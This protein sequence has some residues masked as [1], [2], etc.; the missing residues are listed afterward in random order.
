MLSADNLEWE[1]LAPTFWLTGKA[2]ECYNKYMKR[3]SKDRQRIYDL[4]IQMFR[5]RGFVNVRIEDI[6]AQAGCSVS[7]FYYQF[8]SKDE[9]LRIYFSSD[10]V[11]TEENMALIL[12]QESPWKQLLLLL[13][14]NME[15]YLNA[16]VD[17][18]RQVYHL[19]LDSGEKLGEKEQNSTSRLTA[20]IVRNAQRA[21]E[22]RNLS[23]PAML[24]A[25]ANELT[26]GILIEWIASN[27]AF[28]M[29]KRMQQGAETLHNVRE[30]LRGLPYPFA[31]LQET[32]KA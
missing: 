24:T 30:D 27:G 22:T 29:M 11:L 20:T 16:G 12:E 26:A 2:G 13:Q 10:R 7:K 14:L 6:C 31:H 25:T 4:A 8:K 28:D 3:V 15:V 19:Y 17:L 32:P 18:C 9:L 21:G 1:Q 5:E 23:D